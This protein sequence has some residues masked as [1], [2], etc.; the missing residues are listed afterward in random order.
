MER[1]T[2][3]ID[4][5]VFVYWLTAHPTF[6]QKALHWIKKVEE[7]SRASFVTA[8]LTLYETIVIIAGLT[9]TTL[10]NQK[11]VDKILAAFTT[12]KNLKIIPLTPTDYLE[13]LKL[14]S[15]H[16]LDFE[17]ALHLTVALRKKSREIVSNDKDFDRTP[18][19]R[20]F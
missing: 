19:N 18:L 3:Y 10:R 2:R 14:M 11:L 17:D 4:V 7:G 15:Q 16:S 8:S 12:L 1:L 5:N 6:G 9:R 20:V 13:A